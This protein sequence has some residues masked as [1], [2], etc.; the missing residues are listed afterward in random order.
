MKNLKSIGL[1]ITLLLEKQL[2]II[3]RLMPQVASEAKN[4]LRGIRSK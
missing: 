2:V 1:E 4:L 3:I